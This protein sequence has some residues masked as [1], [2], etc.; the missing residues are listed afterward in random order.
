MKRT[1][2]HG[3]DVRCIAAIAGISG[4]PSKAHAKG[5]STEK[6]PWPYIKLDPGK[7]AELAYNEWYRVF[8]GEAVIS[9]FF[10]QLREKVG[11]PYISFIC[12]EIK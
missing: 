2:E 9:S 1:V 10:S 4:L 6:W 11:E 5:G 12:E 8:C 7:T 3:G